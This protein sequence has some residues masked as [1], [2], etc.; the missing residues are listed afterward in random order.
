MEKNEE[1][2]ADFPKTWILEDGTKV[3]V[4][5]MV[6]QD[7]DRVALFFKRIGEDELCFLKDNV[8]DIRV[9]DR[10]I[11]RLDYDR[12]LPLV[13]D[14]NGRIVAD[15]SLHRRKEGW[16]RHL[17]GVRVVVDPAFRH[18]GLASKLIDELT[19]VAR[20]EGLDRLYAEIPADDQSAIN[21]FQDRGF[22]RVA[23]FEGDI[24]DRT[25]KYHDMAVYHLELT[26]RR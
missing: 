23:V 25:G 6:K 20:K 19:A 26:E 1:L 3:T 17:G 18:K 9:I 15:A 24:I 7:R 10:W 14:I 4:R 11:E 2:L 13:A 16:R 12:V 21:V 5:P 8:T 22:T